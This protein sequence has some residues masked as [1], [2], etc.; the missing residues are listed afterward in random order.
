MEKI[1]LPKCSLDNEG[2]V[3]CKV[4]KTTFDA[5][6]KLGKNPKRLLLEIE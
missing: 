3:T 4:S 2:N 5:V 1:E 6:Q